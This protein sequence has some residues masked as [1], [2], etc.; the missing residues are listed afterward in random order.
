MRPGKEV[1]R[2]WSNIRDAYKRSNKKIQ[3]AAKSGA[4]H[5]KK[6]VNSDQSQFLENMLEVRPTDDSIATDENSDTEQTEESGR[7]LKRPPCGLKKNKNF[8]SD[9]RIVKLQV[10]PE[11]ENRHLSF[12]RGIIPSLSAFNDDEVI[13]LQMGVLQTILKKRGHQEQ[14]I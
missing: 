8:D 7:R 14:E 10:R 13:E 5:L 6:Y 2:R 3:A 9:D 12:F 11:Q 1:I 4:A